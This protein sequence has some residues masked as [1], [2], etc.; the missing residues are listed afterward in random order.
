MSEN[1][2]VK[3]ALNKAMALCAGREYC[4]SDINAKLESWG[5]NDT[6]VNSVISMLIKDDFI[7]DKRYAEAFVRDK[8]HHNKWGKVKIA[9]HLKAKKIASELISSALASLDEDQY[10]QMARDT[11]DSH[12]KHVK[13]KNQYDLKGKLLRFG[14]S[15]GFESNLL[16]DILNEI[17]EK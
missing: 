12:R 2:L 10:R 11:I 14:L 13:A 6:E 3:T 8:Y 5:L 7:N 1:P 17:E 15:K 4:S 16:Y 9:S